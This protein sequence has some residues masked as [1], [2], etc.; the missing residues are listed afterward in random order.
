VQAIGAFSEEE[1]MCDLWPRW[2]NL[3]TAVGLSLLMVARAEDDAA[4]MVDACS[5]WLRNCDYR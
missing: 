2:R 3:S 1:K 5:R 4:V